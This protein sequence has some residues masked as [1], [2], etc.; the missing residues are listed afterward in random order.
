MDNAAVATEEVRGIALS[1]P[2]ACERVSY[3]GQPSWR[4]SRRMFAWIRDDPVALVVRVE[5]L[6]AKESLLAANPSVFG[7]ISHYDG[8]PTILVRLEAVE[9]EDARELVT[10]S[11]RVRAPRGLTRGYTD[12]GPRPAPSAEPRS[13]VGSPGGGGQAGAED[14]RQGGGRQGVAIQRSAPSRV[15]RTVRRCARIAS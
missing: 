14:V 4:T 9:P 15:A 6:E 2:G 3:G 1:L 5:S 13:E 8:Q 10:D 7:T 11:W 12:G